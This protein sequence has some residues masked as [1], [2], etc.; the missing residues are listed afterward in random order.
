MSTPLFSIIIPCYNTAL[1]LAQC[2]E[3]VM[4]QTF[5]NWEI[6]IVNDGSSD[7]TGN[8]ARHYAEQDC[9]IKVFSQKNQGLS[10]ARNN[11]VEKAIGDYILFLDSDDWYKDKSCLEHMSEKIEEIKPDILVF[12]Y[13][14]VTD[15]GHLYQEDY[16]RQCFERM[17]EQLY[18]G[19][20]YL[21]HVLSQSVVYSWYP[22]R[23]AFKRIFWIGNQFVFRIRRFEDVDM[24]YIVLLKAQRISILDEVVYQYRTVREGALTNVSKRSMQDLLYV[25]RNTINTVGRMNIDEKLKS[26]LRNNFSMGYFTVLTEVNYLKRNDRKE[27][28]DILCQNRNL[29]DHTTRR[30]NLLVKGLV[31]VLGLHITSK[32]LFLRLKILVLRCRIFFWVF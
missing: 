23:Y 12:C 13:Q 26:L 16:F 3:S 10:A 21:Y 9:R 17:K 32:V 20:Q 11:G 28:F 5:Q 18:S 1:Y 19:E 8:L 24:I 29:M 6:I 7:N 4:G 27:V 14:R 31:S 30:K 15:D 2:L 22:W 25:S